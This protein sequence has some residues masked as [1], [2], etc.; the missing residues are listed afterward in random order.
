MFDDP[1]VKHKIWGSKVI[2]DYLKTMPLYPN[3]IIHGALKNNI[4]QQIQ[5]YQL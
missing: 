3:V 5:K 1:I 4:E 2:C